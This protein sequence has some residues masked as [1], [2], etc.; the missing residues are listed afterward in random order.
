MPRKPSKT[1]GKEALAQGR[2]LAWNARNNKTMSNKEKLSAGKEGAK[3][4]VK[5][6]TEVN[7]AKRAAA[8]KKTSKKPVRVAK[9]RTKKRSK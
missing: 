8:A 3:R 2:N 1:K 5:G 4:I 9:S 6:I 7:Q